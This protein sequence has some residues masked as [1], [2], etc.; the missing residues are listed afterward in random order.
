MKMPKITARKWEG[1]DMYSW[2]VFIDN[3]VFVSGLSKRQVD[4]YKKLAK[5]TWE[6][7]HDTA[8]SSSKKSLPRA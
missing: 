1:D 8:G 5:Q 7:R 6:E 3:Q 2:A 4:Y